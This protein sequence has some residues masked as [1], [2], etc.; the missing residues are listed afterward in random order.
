M[1]Y[2]CG[3]FFFLAYLLAMAE[4]YLKSCTVAVVFDVGTFSIS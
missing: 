2:I 3:A 4:T 1:F